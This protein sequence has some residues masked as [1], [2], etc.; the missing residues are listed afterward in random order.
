MYTISQHTEGN[1]LQHVFDTRPTLLPVLCMRIPKSCVTNMQEDP[2]GAWLMTLRIDDDEFWN[3]HL[4]VREAAIQGWFGV[5]HIPPPH[6]CINVA[7][8][9]HKLSHRFYEKRGTLSMYEDAVVVD[10]YVAV[11][12]SLRRFGCHTIS[13]DYHSLVLD[14][15]EL[16]K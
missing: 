3:S 14:C 11:W 2:H 15:V 8:P 10:D 13:Q 9:E 4:E 1:S 6:R 16:L 12:V 7:V 5:D